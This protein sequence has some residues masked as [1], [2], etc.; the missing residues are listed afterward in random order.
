MK[1]FLRSDNLLS[2]AGVVLGVA[3]MQAC[4]LKLPEEPSCNFVR[5]SQAQRVSWNSNEPMK[6]YVDS[7]V[8]DSLVPYIRSAADKWNRSAGRE[9]IQVV[10]GVEIGNA[11]AS[12]DGFSK[13]YIQSDW[14]SSRP[15][16]QAR[17]TVHWVGSIMQE[18]DIRLNAKD[19]SFFV[20]PRP[21]SYDQVHFESLV[22]HELGHALGLAHNESSDSVM[23]T[24]LAQGD[25]RDEVGKEDL[26][27]MGC[28]Y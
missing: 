28:E 2:L 13:I 4:S 27:S 24:R 22:L 16:E 21:A 11:S 12:R 5:N 17:T 26:L 8:D 23:Q 10:A 3:L 6:L 15:D 20:G 25:I 9:L 18:A 19:F 7:S 1:R 14:D